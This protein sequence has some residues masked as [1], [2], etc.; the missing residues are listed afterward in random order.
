MHV[1]QLEKLQFLEIA[2]IRRDRHEI[3]GMQK[4]SSGADWPLL[5]ELRRVTAE[6]VLRVNSGPSLF[7]SFAKIIQKT[8]LD[9]MRGLERSVGSR[10]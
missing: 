2:F 5:N 7:A 1:S 8:R 10:S 4:V 3:T 6:E 9:I